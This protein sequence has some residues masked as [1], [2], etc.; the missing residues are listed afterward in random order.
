MQALH[1]KLRQLGKDPWVDWSR[2]PATA[3]WWEE[4]EDAIEAA[5]TSV[6]VISPVSVRSR[7]SHQEIGHAI[8]HNN[9]F[10]LHGSNLEDAE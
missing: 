5:N 4:I 3:K 9:S 2:I 1:D 10:L 8:K 6:F 7:Y